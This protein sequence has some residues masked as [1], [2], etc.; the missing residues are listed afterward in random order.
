MRVWWALLVCLGGA[1][2]SGVAAVLQ[3]LAARAVPD[4]GHGVRPRLLLDLVK[5]WRFLVGF[6]LNLCSFAASFAALRVLTIFLVQSATSA[7]L[8]VTAVVARRVLG[9][10][11]SWVERVAVGGVCVGVA[12]LGL[13]AARQ[14]TEHGSAALHI[15]LLAAVGLLAVLGVLAGWLPLRLSAAGLGLLAGF[16]FGLVN[17]ASRVLTSFAPGDLI[18][19][20]AVYVLPLAGFW[21]FLFYATALQRESVIA[22]TAG[23]VAGQTIFPALVGL[24]LLGDETRPGFEVLAGTGFGV[25]VG[26]AVALARFGDLSEDTPSPPAV[27]A[28]A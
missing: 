27:K 26:C 13:S 8:A 21:A 18:R 24:L 23:T 16:G 20:P 17:V 25:T 15:G 11:L 28:A 7:N 19:D 2:A 14:G 4:T 12:M 5:Q 3:A 22:A 10:H 1:V 6:G 9:T